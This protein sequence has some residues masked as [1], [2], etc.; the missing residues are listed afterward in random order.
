MRRACLL[1]YS[2]IADDPRVRRQGDCLAAAGWDVCA[3]GLPPR[4]AAPPDWPVDAVAPPSPGIAGKM[5]RLARGLAGRVAA[6]A[7]FWLDPT[8]RAILEAAQTVKADLVVAND[9]PMLP[10]AARL[11]TLHGSAV[12]YDS[13]EYA[14][15]QRATDWRW[16][17][18]V[19][20]MAGAIESRH[21]GR[22]QAVCTVSGG[23]ARRLQADHGLAERPTVV[24]N[25]PML[26]DPPPDGGAGNPDGTITVLYQGLFNADRG[27][28]TLVDSVARWH[29]QFRLRLRGIGAPR[30]IR[31]LERAIAASPQRHRIALLPPVPQDRLV[32]AAAEADIGI[33]LLDGHGPQHDFALPN[34]IFEYM[35]AGLA[36]C[37]ID[38]PEIRHILAQTGAGLLVAAPT[39]AAIAEAVNGF[40]AATL[41]RCRAGAR[42]AARC[43]NWQRESAVF[44][45]LC[46]RAVAA[47]TGA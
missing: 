17:L 44:L 33:F 25:V 26:T 1:S 45:D 41:D 7:A 29:P 36:V 42:A 2:P 19:G 30:D 32:D 38:V 5:Q 31:R 46:D 8:L 6:E 9:W 39:A 24:R 11:A 35:M 22:V 34:K 27:L 28:E 15:L 16:R 12:V 20:P 4:L 13:H 43:F 23:I 21:I 40:D 37:S 47:R 14:A 3:V 18:L 10:V